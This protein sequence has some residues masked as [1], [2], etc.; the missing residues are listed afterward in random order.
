M[1][2][3]TD[4]YSIVQVTR[5]TFPTRQ[6]GVNY[7]NTTGRTVFITITCACLWTAS[8]AEV[9]LTGLIN[10][11]EYSAFGIQETPLPPVVSGQTTL[12]GNLTLIARPGD[13]YRVNKT[14]ISGTVSIQNWVEAS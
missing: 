11:L 5:Y 4:P 3:F 2:S 8:E 9:V 10:G 14:Q 7:T 12:T 13:V 1:G 6:A